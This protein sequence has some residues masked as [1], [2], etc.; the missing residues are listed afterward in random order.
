MNAVITNDLLALYKV[1]HKR[2]IVFRNTDM[3]AKLFGLFAALPREDMLTQAN[4][5]L[6]RWDEGAADMAKDILV[7]RADSLPPAIPERAVVAL[8]GY[9]ERF[10]GFD[11]APMLDS[12][13]F[14]QD[15]AGALHHMA[16]RGL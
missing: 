15:P 2:G 13:G 11:D 5:F 14:P 1:D 8:A 10:G 3:G 16:A 9:S 4:W 7:V 12:D 6:Q